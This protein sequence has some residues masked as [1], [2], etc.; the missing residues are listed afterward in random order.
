MALVAL[1]AEAATGKYGLVVVR[2]PDG[3]INREYR[4]TGAEYAA[5]ALPGAGAP[6]GF[7]RADVTAGRS[8]V[9]IGKDLDVGDVAVQPDGALLVKYAEDRVGARVVESFVRFEAGE[10]SGSRADLASVAPAVIANIRQVADP[11]AR[12]V[13]GARDIVSLSAGVLVYAD[14]VAGSVP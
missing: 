13:R 6:V 9:A 12:R 1:R 11:E 8:W 3:T 5:L 4:I 7:V 10:W 2:D 14:V